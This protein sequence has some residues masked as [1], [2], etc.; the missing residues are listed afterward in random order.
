MSDLTD[1]LTAPRRSVEAGGWP[2]SSAAPRAMPDR[3]SAE[4]YRDGR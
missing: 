4:Q 1:A 2:T 3:L